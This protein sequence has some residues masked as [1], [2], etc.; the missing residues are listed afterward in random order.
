MQTSLFSI[1]YKFYKKFLAFN[2]DGFLETNEVKK[3]YSHTRKF[4]NL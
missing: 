1:S 4:K 2:S 3:D